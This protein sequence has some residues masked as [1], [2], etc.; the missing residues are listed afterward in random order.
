MTAF[1]RPDPTEHAEYYAQYIARVPDGEITS[2]LSNQL[3]ETVGILRSLPEDRETY[4]YAEDKWTL[5]EV[6]GHLIDTERMFAYRAL[7]IAREDD[8]DLPGMDQ[9]AWNRGSNAA[10]RAMVDLIDEWLLVRRS[11]VVMFACMPDGVGS[12]TGRASG[13]KFTGRS[14][15]WIIAGHELW[16]RDLIRRDYMAGL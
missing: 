5:R 2:T 12:R 15:P 13:Y 10:D 11:N 6:V 9:D 1:L 16:H 8:V 3:A 14:F 7:A 4:R